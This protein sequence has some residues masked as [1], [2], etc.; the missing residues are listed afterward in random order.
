MDCSLWRRGRELRYY[1]V[2]GPGADCTDEFRPT[3]LNRAE[4]VRHAPL[5]TQSLERFL[6]EE[7]QSHFDLASTHRSGATAVP[8]NVNIKPS[9]GNARVRRNSHE[10]RLIY[11]LQHGILEAL[12]HPDYLEERYW[13]GSNKRRRGGKV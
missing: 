11:Q 6:D 7:L 5:R 9:Q 8:R 1:Q 10:S 12:T 3:T 4:H 13:F 2:V